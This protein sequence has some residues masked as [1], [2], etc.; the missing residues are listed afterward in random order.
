MNNKETKYSTNLSTVSFQIQQS[1][2]TWEQTPVFTTV[3]FPNELPLEQV[4]SI[5]YD[6]AQLMADKHNKEVRWECNG[7]GQGHYTL[8]LEPFQK[9]NSFI[10]LLDPK[11]R[12]RK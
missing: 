5:A 9:K 8:P 1:E 12:K 10:M 2:V 3:S 7:S 6:I 11:N 4:K